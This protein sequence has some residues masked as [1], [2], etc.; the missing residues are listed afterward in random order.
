M[1]AGV[2]ELFHILEFK[3][4]AHSFSAEFS[5]FFSLRWSFALVAQARVQWRDLS[6]LQPLPLRFKWFSCFSLLSSWYYRCQS[7]YPANFCIFS[8]D[9][10]LPC[11]PGWS[12]SL[13]LVI[14]PPWPPKVLGLQAWVAAPGLRKCIFVFKPSSLFVRIVW[15]D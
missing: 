4:R 14:H 10:V 7:P 8:R 12:R 6:S 15:V 3:H 9:E 13:D 11:W 2:G 5:F 1:L